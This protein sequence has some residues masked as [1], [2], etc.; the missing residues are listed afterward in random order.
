VL[1]VQLRSTR[2]APVAVAVNPVGTVGG[3]VSLAALLVVT[4]SWG[5][6]PAAPSFDE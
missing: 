2:P 6:E 5:A 1:A 3:F 4:T